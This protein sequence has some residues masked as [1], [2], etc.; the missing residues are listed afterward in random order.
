MNT[1]AL[2]A[3]STASA[4]GLALGL[5]DGSVLAAIRRADLAGA[6]ERAEGS[7]LQ[8]LLD[9]LVQDGP[10]EGT[11]AKT[12]D[13]LYEIRETLRCAGKLP[14][15][16]RFPA[17]TNALSGQLRRS[18]P[19]LRQVGFVI[20]LDGSGGRDKSKHKVWTIDYVPEKLETPE[21][22]SMGS[23]GVAAE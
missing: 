19:D 1:E 17:S 7:P 6:T 21:A 22:G 11:P 3:D 23:E 2:L 18:A 10:W 8:K 20:D 16:R 12:Y 15:D 5:P 9:E 13:R 14:D 4:A